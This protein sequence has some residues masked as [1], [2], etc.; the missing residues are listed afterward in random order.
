MTPNK[1][2]IEK[3]IEAL[4]YSNVILEEYSNILRG[5]G[6]NATA[7]LNDACLAKNNQAL[8]LLREYKPSECRIYTNDDGEVIAEIPRPK[9]LD[10]QP[11]EGVRLCPFCQSKPVFGLGRKTGCQLH[12][13]PIQYVTLGCKN[14]DCPAAPTVTGGDMYQNG[15]GQYFKETEKKAR[16]F[17]VQKWNGTQALQGAGG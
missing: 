12:G 8:Q 2:A 1:D 9:W 6:L 16:E 4:D 7:S 13:D 17:A 5:K 10:E 14:R 3:A 15:E 11:S